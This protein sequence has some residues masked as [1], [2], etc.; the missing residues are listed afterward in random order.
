MIS[1][2]DLPEQYRD[3]ARVTV[4]GE[5]AGNRPSAA[6]SSGVLEPVLAAHVFTWMGRLR[7]EYGRVDRASGSQSDDICAER[8]QRGI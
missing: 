1:R 7:P 8:S 4:V 3:W 6:D 5:V 2:R